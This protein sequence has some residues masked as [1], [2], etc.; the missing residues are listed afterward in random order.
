[1]KAMHCGRPISTL[2]LLDDM[3]CKP[4]APAERAA[5]LQAEIGCFK[6]QRQSF[7][8]SDLE[9]IADI[10]RVYGAPL[11]GSRGVW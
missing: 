1:L 3:Q 10:R 2:E 11:K 6:G 8:V 5:W 9:E 4:D 7:K